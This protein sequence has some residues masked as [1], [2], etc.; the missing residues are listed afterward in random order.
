MFDEFEYD[1]DKMILTKS[2]VRYNIA[3][4]L[5]IL[6]HKSCFCHSMQLIL[7]YLWK[8]DLFIAG[9]MDEKKEEEKKEEAAADDGGAGGDGGAGDGGKK[10]KKKKKAAK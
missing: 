2:I 1:D 7:F 6:Y 3:Q 5:F 4:K 9:G 10:K 8:V